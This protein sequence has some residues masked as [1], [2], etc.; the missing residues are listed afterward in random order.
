MGLIYRAS[1]NLHLES[2]TN[3]WINKMR[4]AAMGYESGERE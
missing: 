2:L 3:Q 4:G 1:S